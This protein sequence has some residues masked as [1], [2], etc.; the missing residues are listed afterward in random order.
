MSVLLRKAYGL[1]GFGVI[2]VCT[3]SQT[4]CQSSQN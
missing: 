1:E 3:D 4:E 2:E